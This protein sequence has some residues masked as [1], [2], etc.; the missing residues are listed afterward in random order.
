MDLG[1]VVVERGRGIE[2]LEP[3]RGRVEDVVAKQLRPKLLDGQLGALT[4]ATH[5]AQ[6]DD[7]ALRFNLDDRP[8]EAAPVGPGGMA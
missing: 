2:D 4:P 8:D 3:Q 6:P 5:L 7:A 1:A